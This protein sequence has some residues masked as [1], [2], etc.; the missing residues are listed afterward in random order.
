MSKIDDS[1]LEAIAKVRILHAAMAKLISCL[2]V[3]SR[4]L[5]QALVSIEQAEMW[6]SRSIEKHGVKLELKK[7]AMVMLEDVAN[8]D[9]EDIAGLQDVKMPKNY[10]FM[11]ANVYEVLTE[12]MRVVS[13]SYH[14]ED[15]DDDGRDA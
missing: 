14:S 1:K 3:D 12:L 8:G 10:E 13:I 11:L 9:I 4:E 2:L 7:C 6:T 15:G 5:E